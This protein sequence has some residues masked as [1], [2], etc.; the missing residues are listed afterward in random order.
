MRILKLPLGEGYRLLS[1]NQATA[2][3]TG[4]QKHP[5][6]RSNN[7]FNNA[8]I[9]IILLFHIDLLGSLE[10]IHDIIDNNNFVTHTP[11]VCGVCISG[12]DRPA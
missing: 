6:I 12:I 1:V 3:Q 10:P 9:S 4:R 2:Q 5:S 7:H 11:G 8:I